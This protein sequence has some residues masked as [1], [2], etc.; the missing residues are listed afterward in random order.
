MA[1]LFSESLVISLYKRFKNILGNKTSFSQNM[2]RRCYGSSKYLKKLLCLLPKYA[3]WNLGRNVMCRA[4][5]SRWAFN[6][7]QNLITY[8]KMKELYVG[9]K[10]CLSRKKVAVG[11]LVYVHHV[12]ELRIKSILISNHKHT[13]SGKTA[14]VFC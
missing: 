7:I 5:K 10:S 12:Q 1:N 14:N 3:C 2:Y 8:Y 4:Q 6:L 9:Q 13:L 11:H